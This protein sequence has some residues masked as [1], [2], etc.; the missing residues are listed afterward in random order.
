M[1]STKGAVV[2]FFIVS[3]AL[4]IFGKQILDVTYKQVLKSEF[5]ET[6]LYKFHVNRIK[7]FNRTTQVFDG[8]FELFVDYD[9]NILESSNKF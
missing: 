3:T 6:S 4:V 9:N 7:K 2:Y 1:S 8:C 5:T